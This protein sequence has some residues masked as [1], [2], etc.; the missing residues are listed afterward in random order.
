MSSW[1][2]SQSRIIG[3]ATAC[4]LGP[5]CCCLATLPPF[6]ERAR[7]GGEARRSVAVNSYRSEP[8]HFGAVFMVEFVAV[9]G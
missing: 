4:L 8:K 1:P 2:G 7:W 6:A 9:R 5:G 3:S